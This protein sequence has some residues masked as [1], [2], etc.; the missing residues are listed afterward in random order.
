MINLGWQEILLILGLFLF[1]V[2]P[3]KLPEIA[4][5]LA[6]IW[7]EINRASTD[8]MKIVTS[9]A[10]ESIETKQGNKAATSAMKNQTSEL[11]KETLKSPIDEINMKNIDRMEE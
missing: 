8:V 5:K 4:K 1:V 6:R 7:N 3:K 9:S 2:G 11:E 10:T